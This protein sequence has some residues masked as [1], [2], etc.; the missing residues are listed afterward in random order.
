[1]DI[2]PNSRTSHIYFSLVHWELCRFAVF[3]TLTFGAVNGFSISLSPC[4]NLPLSTDHLILSRQ[5]MFQDAL[6]YVTYQV[7]SRT[8]QTYQVTHTVTFS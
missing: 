8:L 1:M 2:T 4:H 7:P 3:D 5:L 6:L